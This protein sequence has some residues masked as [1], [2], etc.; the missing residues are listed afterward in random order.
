MTEVNKK[1]YR[2][3]LE[4]GNE[5]RYYIKILILGKHGVGKST[6]LKNLLNEPIDGVEPTD[7]IDI[8][9]KSKV[10]IKNG[11]WIFHEGNSR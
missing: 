3:I 9:K 5:K 4:D 2:K 10:N 7:G 8:V 1:I 6:L 11:E